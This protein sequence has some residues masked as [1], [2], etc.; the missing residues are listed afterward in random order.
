MFGWT[1]S[2][3]SEEVSEEGWGE[4]EDLEDDEKGE[5]ECWVEEGVEEDGAGG[6]GRGVELPHWLEYLLVFLSEDKYLEK[7]T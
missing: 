4:G 6:G 7:L 5:D 3:F 1:D 2:L